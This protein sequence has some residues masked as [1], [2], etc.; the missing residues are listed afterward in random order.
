MQYSGPI[1]MT[2]FSESRCQ[3]YGVKMLEFNG[4]RHTL[5]TVVIIFK[6]RNFFFS[7]Y[8]PICDKYYSYRL[9]EKIW[10]EIVII[11]MFHGCQIWSIIWVR[12][13]ALNLMLTVLGLQVKVQ[14]RVPSSRFAP[15]ICWV[16][17]TQLTKITIATIIVTFWGIFRQFCLVT[18]IIQRGA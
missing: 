18:E 12:Y 7:F 5:T 16:W 11:F 6:A 10:Q 13:T 15:R 14:V 2:I 17:S 9:P 3:A 1:F 4:W 8:R